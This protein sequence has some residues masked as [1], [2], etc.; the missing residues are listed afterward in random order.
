[1]TEQA[2]DV[3]APVTPR[4]KTRGFWQRLGIRLLAAW[5]VLSLLLWLGGPPLLKRILP[6]AVDRKL[7]L[8][9]EVQDIH[10]NPLRGELRVDGLRIRD[11]EQLLVGAGRIQANLSLA[12]LWRGSISLD[13]AQLIQPE[14]NALIDADGQL[15]LMKLVPPKDPNEPDSKTRWAIDH[16]LL[17]QG[18]VHFRDEHLQ[19]VVDVRF[20]ASRVDVRDLRS[21]DSEPG[22]LAF[23][24]QLDD[25]TLLTWHGKLELDKLRSQGEITLQG[26][27]LPRIEAMLPMPMPV[28]ATSGRLGLRLPYDVAV[29]AGKPVLTIKQGSVT[30]DDLVTRIRND[31]QAPLRLPH[32]GINGIDV[33]WPAQTVQVARIEARGGEVRLQ[34]DSRGHLTLVDALQTPAGKAGKAARTHGQAEATPTSASA[35]A[36][37]KPTAPWQIS[38]G[39]FALNDWSVLWQDATTRPAVKLALTPLNLTLDKITWPATAPVPLMLETGFDKGHLRITGDLDLKQ[40]AAD[41]QI[42]SES[43]PLPLLQPYIAQQLAIRLNKGTAGSHLQLHWDTGSRGL[44]VQGDAG[45]RDLNVLATADNSR[46]LG[47]QSLQARGLDLQLKRNQMRLANVQ[48]DGLYSQVLI[49]ANKQLNL[50]QLVLP[51]GGKPAAATTPDATSPDAAS[52]AKPATPPA[53]AK[54]PGMALSIG[55]VSVR[56]SAM[57]FADQSMTPGFATGIEQLSGQVTGLDSRDVSSA[58]VDLKGVVAPAGQVSI[59][60]RMNPLASNL[61]LDMALQF[62][63]LELSA[64]TPYAARFAGYRIDR[65]KLDI[66]LRYQIEKRALQAQNKVVL[67]QLRLGD[68]VDSPEAIGI[69]L[70]LAVAILRDVD[71]NIDIDLP[72]SGSLDNPEFSIGPIIWKAFLNLL[73]RAATAPF[74]ML[75]SL[76][77]G[78]DDLSNVPFAVG[79]SE[80]T[81]AARDNLGKL[82]KALTSRP[83]LQLEVRGLSDPQADR[84]ALQVQKAEAELARRQ[85]GRK[86][87][88]IEGLERYLRD[89]D[90]RSAVSRLRELSQVPDPK[91]KMVLNEAGYEARLLD[92]LASRQPVADAELG[93]LARQRGQAIASALMTDFSVPSARIFLLDSGQGGAHDGQI[94]VPLQLGA[95]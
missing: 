9:A 31:K 36:E 71:D 72:I 39:Q 56:R 41:L 93:N 21:Y 78:G 68:K 17:D 11:G 51:A 37:R 55:K 88:R 34:R 67:R 7:H 16:F 86:D 46:L 24:T 87:S 83:A 45:L 81:P 58:R 27:P 76:I 26:L 60:G 80:L 89:V 53:P 69:P 2:S 77:G 32:V 12:S 47:A 40:P 15:N 14:V 19:P 59:N 85:Q 23:R 44:T 10:I 91:G 52:P 73:T 50:A 84:K 35:A 4:W 95:R 8:Q 29:T 38:L 63:E 82:A 1:M 54:A 79:S 75:G 66:D 61:S 70:K 3:P 43:L 18:K 92:A 13:D 42:D 57:L 30:L 49:N 64:L 48:V 20:D 65:G 28:Q 22:Q 90:S 6:W 62:H 25:D 33:A 94:S 5:A 74:S